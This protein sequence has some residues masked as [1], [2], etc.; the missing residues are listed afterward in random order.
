VYVFGTLDNRLECCNCGLVADFDDFCAATAAEM[1]THLEEHVARGDKVLH[2]AFERLR[3]E[4]RA[5]T[6]LA[7]GYVRQESRWQLPRQLGL[8][9]VACTHAVS[10][11]VYPDDPDEY[12]ADYHYVGCPE[13]WVL[14][15]AER[16][17]QQPAP[18]DER[19]RMLRLA[20]SDRDR[21]D[22][23]LAALRIGHAPNHVIMNLLAV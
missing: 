10:R 8:A 6:L 20:V 11:G 14:A 23:L 5:E 16:I 4:A 1:I 21:Q 12:P 17:A 18:I 19:R 13:Q 15:W 2:Y 3:I 7:A 9:R 22:A